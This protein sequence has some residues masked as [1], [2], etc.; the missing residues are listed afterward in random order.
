[1]RRH[2]ILLSCVLTLAAAGVP[3]TAQ[4]Q[5]RVAHLQ[6]ASCAGAIDWK[7]ARGLI[8][9]VATIRGRVAGTKYAAYSNG[10][11][12]FLSLGVD[13]PSARRVTVVIWKE[14]RSKFG[15]SELRY[16]GRTVCVHGFVDSYGGVPEIEASSPSQ[17]L[18]TH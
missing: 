6:F 7:N 11:P 3:G 10:S 15:A 8:G 9:R 13:Y 14:N 1:M 2:I 12:T 16:R 18:I 4:A 5:T 17:I